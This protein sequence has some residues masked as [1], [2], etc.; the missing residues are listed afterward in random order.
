MKGRIEGRGNEAL[1]LSS[2]KVIRQPG[3]AVSNPVATFTF[4]FKDVF[5][6]VEIYSG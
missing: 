5:I 3:I 1:L 4:R 6:K 2:C